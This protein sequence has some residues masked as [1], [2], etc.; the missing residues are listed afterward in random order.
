MR[1][2]NV[3]Y[4]VL[5]NE[6]SL[7][8]IFCNLMS[9]KVFR[10]MFID[11]VNEKRSEDNKFTKQN[12]GYRDFSTEK[13]FG[14]I[15]EC[16]KDEENNK[17]GRGDLILNYNDEDFI[18]E[19]KVEKYTELTKNQPT[20]YL[21]YLKKQNEL[22]FNDYLYFILPKGYMHI[23]QIV[24]RWDNY[25][26]EMIQNNHILYWEDILSEIRKRE[27]HK[28]NIIINEFCEILDY[29]WFYSKPIHFSQNEIE[30]IFQP[31]N[32]KNEELQMAFDTNI[33]KI[34]GKLFD[35]V[36]NIKYKVHISKKND[37]QNPNYYGYFLDNKK[38]NL[39]DGLDIWFGVTYEIWE[40]VGVPILIDI[41]SDDEQL[42][43]QI[44]G[45]KRFEYE[46]EENSVSYYIAFD[47]SFYS[48]DNLAQKIEDKILEIVQLLKIDTEK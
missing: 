45:L 48:E 15:Q 2:Q 19:L 17:I 41:I 26:K 12:I 9:Y 37:E 27:L 21:C 24:S 25:P 31:H 16:F 1:E 11:I 10:D 44:E 29:R 32:N 46:D 13:N 34:M 28:L 42:L 38:Y 22:C 4:N 18:F 3:F 30:L 5:K 43:S 47:K 8:E 23:E 6:T 14:E 40:K 36:D 7:T 20:G 39:P 35:I 33:P